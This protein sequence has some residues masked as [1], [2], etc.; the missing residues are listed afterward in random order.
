MEMLAPAVVAV[1][2]A[3][4]PDD[5]LL[6]TLVSLGAQDYE[7]LTVL[8]LLTPEAAGYQSQIAESGLG[9]EVV[10][11]E[12]DRGFGA[13]VNAGMGQI[14]GAAFLLLCHD[15]VVLA[16]DAVHLL[17]EESFRSNA[18]VV[19][20]KVV[21][22]AD[23]S[24]LLH[25]GQSVD[26]LGVVVDRVLPGEIDQGQHDA[27]RDVFVAPG[28]VTLVRSDLFLSLGGFD[29]RYVAMGDDLDLSW[30]ARLLGARI[31]CAPQAVVAHRERLAAGKRFLPPVEELR[32]IS[33]S[34]LRRRNELRSVLTFWR[35]PQRL[36]SIIALAVF[37]IAEALLAAIGGD[38]DRAVD[39]REAWRTAWRERKGNAKVR[40]QVAKTRTV[41]DRTVRSFQ[42]KGAT[43][44]R[45]FASTFLHHG[46]DAARGV[47]PPEE[48]D[49][50]G[51]EGS[52]F[53]GFGGAFS[54]DEGFDELDDLGH[55]GRRRRGRTLASA[56]TL[57]FAV[58]AVFIVYLIGCRSLI[59]AKL[60]LI[61]QLLPLG[62]LGN[63][64]HSAWAT[65]Q[66][67]GL[68]S[69]AP[70]HPAYTTLGLFGLVAFGQMGVVIR[71][72][73]IFALPIGALGVYR[74]VAPVISMRARVLSVLAYGG[75]ALGVNAIA[76]GSVSGLVAVAAT[77]FLMRRILRLCR[78]APFDAPFPPA[79]PFATRGWRRSSKGQ[80]A[81]LGLLLALLGSLAPALL[82]TTVASN[83]G[84][85]V[86]SVLRRGGRPLAGQGRVLMAVLLAGVLM[87]PLAVTAALGGL[88]GLS[89][90]GAA[91][92]PWST[93]GVGGLL[94]F[95]VGP[96]GT[97]V[98]SWF[99]PA[100]ALVPLLI[101]R[102]E[103]LALSGSLVGIG[104]MSLA[105]ALWVARGGWGTF[106]PDL[107]VVLAPLATAMA[108]LVASE[109]ESS[110]C[111][112][113][114]ASTFS[115]T[116]MASSTTM[117][118]ASTIASREMVLAE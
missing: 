31:V 70:G 98:L 97:G 117:P 114:T 4:Q 9:C 29:E 44:F 80:V 118:I 74:L 105:L 95:A 53:V 103:R 86:V 2:V 111:A 68:G 36:L 85:I 100:A 110:G 76:T 24:V 65:W 35:L 49:A 112:S 66:P 6:D 3:S 107:L 113:I 46:Y 52:Q 40:K 71:A 104:S 60:P 30:R 59:G 26:R 5:S 32:G 41:S 96:S 16:P 84:L 90:F 94:R 27:V 106:S 78:V 109:T 72:L 37:N 116:T 67:A 61:G 56:R 21:S 11:L 91:L 92:G 17:V 48:E 39:V 82:V 23:P 108:C 58:V 55:K 22:A 10:V 63:V 33:P 12:S 89:V 88:Q 102:D 50:Y 93:P 38:H 69:G 99:L 45:R 25:V 79:V 7:A 14:S 18:A 73:L 47:I 115:T 57:F 42:S 8:V 20:P 64:W 28:G 62:S 34:R 15:D 13:S 43:R 101:A 87:A 51:D 75:L 81:T 1:V 19:T 83:I 77:P 54:D